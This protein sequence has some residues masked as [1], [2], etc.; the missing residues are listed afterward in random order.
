M[1]SNAR[2]C[3]AD[4]SR[5]TLLSVLFRV[6]LPDEERRELEVISLQGSAKILIPNQR[7]ADIREFQFRDQYGQ[8]GDDQSEY[9]SVGILAY[10]DAIRSVCGPGCSGLRDVAHPCIWPLSF[11]DLS[12]G[13]G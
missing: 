6:R 1:D 13:A 10:C 11:G 3:L 8:Y 5:I 9:A 4:V 2:T 7:D 12:D